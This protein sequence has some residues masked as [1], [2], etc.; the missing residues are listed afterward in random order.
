MRSIQNRLEGRQ[1]TV[2]L[3]GV[4]SEAVSVDSGV[5]QGS[6]Q[7]PGLFL[8]HVNDLQSRLTSKVRLFAD[9]TIIYLTIANED[10]AS[11][12]QEHLNKLG[13]WENEWCMK[14]RRL[15]LTGGRLR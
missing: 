14:F 5:H 11:I 15:V 8:F 6:E 2:V 1:Q 10:D 7:G 9:D 3:D 13:Q 12:L 4:S